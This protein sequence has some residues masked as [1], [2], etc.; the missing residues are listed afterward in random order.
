MDR[1]IARYLPKRRRRT[2]PVER[3]ISLMVEQRLQAPGTLNQAVTS[4]R[5][6]R[7]GRGGK[8]VSPN[9]GGYS[10]ARSRLPLAMCEDMARNVTAGLQSEMDAGDQRP[11]YIID[12]SELRLNHAREL[13]DRYPP[14]VNQ[15]GPSH[16]PML[17]IVVV[18]DART[19]LAIDAAW[20]AMFGPHAAGELTLLARTWD[21][22]PKGATYIADRNFGIFAVAYA[23][24]RRESHMVLRLN[25]QIAKKLVPTL[26]A[27]TDM[28]VVWT[29][30]AGERRAH[31]ELPA[32]ARV[33][34]RVIIVQQE[35]WREPLYL[36]TTLHE[37]S[38]E[39]V[40]M[41]G[42]RWN[43]ETDLRS[44]KQTVRLQGITVASA[45]MLD[46]ELWM[47]L[48][49][50][51]LVRAVM[52]A[53]ARNAGID[54]RQLSFTSVYHYVYASLPKL[55]ANPG[56]KSAQKELDYVVAQAA[57]CRLPQRKKRR[58]FPRE[59]WLRRPPFPLRK[60]EDLTK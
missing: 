45:S 22:L 29:P 21:R 23:V 31:T 32:D 49:A 37:P 50:Y 24:A 48:L 59:V 3:V 39:V 57:R 56:S 2:Y 4:V 7:S 43:V 47:A 5:K 58:S 36:F 34:G 28:L 44:I 14:C 18:H 20:G 8:A 41:Y 13:V 26:A 60:R 17:R 55:V 9:T 19:G 53:A 33:E 27:G 38:S 46:K 54:P 42:L 15:Y 6:S 35:G 52:F 12:G 51:N 16:W 10:Q 11:V 25:K 40:R 30:S 1:L